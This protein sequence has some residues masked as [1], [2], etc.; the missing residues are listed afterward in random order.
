MALIK[1][2]MYFIGDGRN[3]AKDSNRKYWEEIESKWRSMGVSK[4][5]T[6]IDRF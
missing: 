5:A 1:V 4:I 3:T 2:F 6:V